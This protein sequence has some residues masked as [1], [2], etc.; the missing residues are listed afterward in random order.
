MIAIYGYE[1]CDLF[2]QKELLQS[3]LSTKF[4]FF[5]RG[6]AVVFMEINALAAW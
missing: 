1:G 5:A 3:Y 4:F 6:L 2:F